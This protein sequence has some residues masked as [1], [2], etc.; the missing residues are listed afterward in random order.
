MGQETNHFNETLHSNRRDFVRKGLLVTLSG[1]ACIGACFQ[2]VT[3]KEEKEDSKGQEVSP[4]R[5]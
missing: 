4:R 2:D 5:Y 1:V 3:G